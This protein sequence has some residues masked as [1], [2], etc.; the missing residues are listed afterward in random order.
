VAILDAAIST[1]GD[2]GPN[3]ASLRDVAISAGVTHPL[4]LQHFDSK[5]GLI[6]AVGERLTAHVST[7]LAAVES[8][9]AAGFSRLLR[10]ARDNRSMTKLLIRSALGDISPDGF[11][12]CLGGPWLLPGDGVD[13]DA[14]R[15]AKMCQ[16]AASS[17]LVGWLTFD[18]FIE[19]A[20]RL[21][22]RG[23][24][25]RDDAIAAVAAH[26]WACAATDDPLFESGP[27][28]DDD[29]GAREA[30]PSTA[31]ATQP[32]TRDALLASAIELFA[33]HGPASVS[34]R[35]VARHAGM[36]H[37]LLHRHFGS[38][39]AL[40]AEAIE[41]GIAPLMPGALAPGGLDIDQV[42]AVMHRDAI[43]ARLIARTLVDDI[44][45]GSVRVRYPVMEGVLDQARR[46]SVE[47]RPAC[48]ADP[49]IAAAATASMVAGSVIWGA[50]LRAASGVEGDVR[51]ALT[52]LSH[53]LLGVPRG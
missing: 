19:S 9:D 52:G 2:A 45:M 27:I 23:R 43:P 18:G 28:A 36:N 44:D 25:R 47:S 42:V 26:L 7:E 8:C 53:H 16:Y 22:S 11:P 34:I 31:T 20:L 1:Y 33:Q 51:P 12:A 14:D 3:G 13:N 50:S 5:D 46:A 30:P 49:V 6:T 10:S 29:Q 41:V 37:G 48:V 21:G 32:T 38:K 17:L 39:D 40:I 24:R 4:V 15:R 35:D